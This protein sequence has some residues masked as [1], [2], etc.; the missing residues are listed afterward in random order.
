MGK[1]SEAL[2]AISA[3]VEYW[4]QLAMRRFVSDIIVRMERENIT[5]AQLAERMH[6]SPAYVSRAL[7]GDINFTLETMT[8]LAMASGGKLDVRVVESY[9]HTA[10]TTAEL[11]L[12]RVTSAVTA[13]ASRSLQIEPANEADYGW[14]PVAVRQ[15]RLVSVGQFTER[16]YAHG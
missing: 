10:M 5:R 8:K 16:R 15:P 9:Q 14:S 12:P 13:V 3:S 6:V 1:Y 11:Q 7:K 4:A 2:K